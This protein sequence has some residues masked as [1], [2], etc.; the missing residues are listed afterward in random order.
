MSSEYKS[1]LSRLARAHTAQDLEQ[2]EN[3]F[4][5]LYNAGI[6]TDAEFSGL[7]SKVMV[8]LIKIDQT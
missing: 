4:T 6:F 7:D 5:R 3:S 1:A 8:R 2:L